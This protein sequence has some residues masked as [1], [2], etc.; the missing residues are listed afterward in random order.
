MK[1][2][3]LL[4]NFFSIIVPFIFSF[5]PAIQFHKR[6]NAFIPANLIT[7]ILF[8]VWDEVFTSAGVW[9]F[10][11]RYITG[12][13]FLNLPVEEIL[14]FICIP[15]ACVFT[16]HVFSTHL[17]LESVIR[18]VRPVRI[19]LPA[20]LII[21]ALL[22]QEKIYTSVTF[23]FL[24]ILLLFFHFNNS[25]TWLDKAVLV[26]T[27]LLLPFF[28]VNGLLTGSMLSEPVVWYNDSENLGIRLFT[29]PMEDIFY[30]MAL[31]LLNIYLMERIESLKK[32]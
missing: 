2:T 11:P 28:I 7:A 20:I 16:Y 26:Y 24:S 13:Y 21:I 1:Y 22:N 6:W 19:V 30:G 29:I 18:Y 14:F 10:N 4:I 17:K 25:R 12:V 31:I 5:H 3:Y 32:A 15:Y 9:G 8:L 27:V 23:L